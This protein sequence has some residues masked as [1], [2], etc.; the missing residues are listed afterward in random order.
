M[1]QF[2]ND[3]KL[4]IA[5]IIVIAAGEVALERTQNDVASTEICSTF[6]HHFKN[7]GHLEHGKSDERKDD[8]KRR[9][10]LDLGFPKNFFGFILHF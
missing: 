8:D 10:A 3:S 7:A 1:V 2:L 4:H 6:R 5:L 9:T